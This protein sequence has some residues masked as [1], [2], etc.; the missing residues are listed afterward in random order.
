MATPWYRSTQGWLDRVEN[1]S[2]TVGPDPVGFNVSGYPVI[3][4]CPVSAYQPYPN[5]IAVMFMTI[6]M[7]FAAGCMFAGLCK[8]FLWTSG[9]SWDQFCTLHGRPWAMQRSQYQEI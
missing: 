4:C 1:T 2:A 9:L 7:V 3:N 8:V 5:Y 6:S